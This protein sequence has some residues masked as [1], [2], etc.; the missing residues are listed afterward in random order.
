MAAV[1]FDHRL[2]G[3]ACS[4]R[5]GLGVAADEG[6]LL[7][8]NAGAIESLRTEGAEH[9][10]IAAAIEMFD[11]KFERTQLVGALI[12]IRTRLRDV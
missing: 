2:G 11:G 8:Q 9:A 3:S 5:L 12:C 7:A 4:V 10:A 1:F 6:D